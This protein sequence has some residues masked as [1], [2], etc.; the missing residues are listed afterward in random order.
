M[1]WH[2]PQPSAPL[3]NSIAP[4]QPVVPLP[5]GPAYFLSFA[6]QLMVQLYPQP[7]A[8]LP[9]SPALS[10]ISCISP[11]YSCAT[12]MVLLQFY[13]MVQP[14]FPPL[15][16]YL[17]FSPIP[18]ISAKLDSSPCTQPILLLPPSHGAFV[19]K[20]CSAQMPS[21]LSILEILP[22]AWDPFGSEFLL[23][24]SLS[25]DLFIYLAWST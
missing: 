19:N 22:T 3:H 24:S 5:D 16:F 13:L 4:S 11:F 8:P 6:P 18:Y 15:K 9:N 21:I 25:M 10:P 7:P 1:A 12:V 2:Y 14:C 20:V 23:P 17:S